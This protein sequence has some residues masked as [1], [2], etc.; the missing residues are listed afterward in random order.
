MGRESTKVTSTALWL[1]WTW[2]TGFAMCLSNC[3]PWL[4]SR[5]RTGVD[6]IGSCTM[7]SCYKDLLGLFGREASRSPTSSPAG[8][9]LSGL[10]TPAFSQRGSA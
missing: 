5:L 2:T 1:S 9:T 8:R 3:L 6:F 4:N 10:C 7:T